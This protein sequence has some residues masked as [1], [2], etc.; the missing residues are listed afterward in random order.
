MGAADFD[1]FAMTRAYIDGLPDGLDS[2]PEVTIKGSMARGMIELQPDN[3]ALSRLPIS[4]QPLFVELPLVSQWMPEVKL[5]AMCC[6]VREAF[7]DDDDTYLNWVRGGLRSIFSSPLYRIAFAVVSP[8]RLVKSATKRWGAI[9]Q[10]TEREIVELN[11]N[12]NLGRVRH[13]PGLYNDLYARVLLA[14]LL[15]IYGLSRAPNPIGEVLEVSTHATLIE[16]LYDA[17]RPRGPAI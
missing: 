3:F 13:P 16:I 8:T 12:G 6:A 9:R 15:A 2:Y 5:I 10:G 14:G 11:E 7:F 4:L 17:S 1:G